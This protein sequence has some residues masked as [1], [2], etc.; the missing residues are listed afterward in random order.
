VKWTP[1]QDSVLRQL[2]R[3]LPA[4]GI[5]ARLGKTRDA[6]I[7]RARR[8]GLSTPR[9]TIPLSLGRHA[10]AQRRYRARKVVAA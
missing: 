4:Q 2:W 8:L 1:R 6:V 3:Q 5:G 10:V 7:G 9:G